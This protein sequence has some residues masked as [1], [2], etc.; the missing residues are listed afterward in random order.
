MSQRYKRPVSG[1]LLRT[2]AV[3]ASV[4]LTASACGGSSTGG[5]GGGS[6][7]SGGAGGT[8]TVAS[9]SPPASLDPAKANVGSDNWYVNLTYDTLLRLGP[10]N[11]RVRRDARTVTT[12]VPPNAGGCPFAHRCPHAVDLC[13][14]ERP[15]LRPAAGG[16]AVACHRYAELHP[17]PQG[18]AQGKVPLT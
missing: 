4:A 5:S 9:M 2:L 1:A 11:Q 12:L 17:V 3:A 7:G 10:K 13:R 6:T 8:L 15:T 14:T 18:S 16:T